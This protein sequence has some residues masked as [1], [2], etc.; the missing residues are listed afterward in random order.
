MVE[1]TPVTSTI[2]FAPVSLFYL[3]GILLLKDGGGLLVDDKFPLLDCTV[4]L[5]GTCRL[6]S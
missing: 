1:K 4:D 6:Y 2:H 3:G 5:A